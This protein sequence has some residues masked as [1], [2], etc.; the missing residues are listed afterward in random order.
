MRSRYTAFVIIDEA[1]LLWTWHPETSPGPLELDPEQRWTGLEV[2]VT[3]GGGLVDQ[4]GTVEFRASS[5]AGVLHERS[6]FARVDGRWVYVDGDQV[7]A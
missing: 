1:Y 5:S 7:T 3:T 2:L 6:R 4:E